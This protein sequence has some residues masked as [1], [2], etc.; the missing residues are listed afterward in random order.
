VSGGA[1]GGR[2]TVGAIV[3]RTGHVAAMA[4]VVGGSWL[5]APGAALRTWG[6][7]TALTGLALAVIEIGHGREWPWQGRG[8]ASLAHVSVLVLLAVPGAAPA[9]TMAALVLGMAGSHMP[10]AWRKWSFRLRA[11][12]DD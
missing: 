10:R 3:L 11:V 5:G 8:V 2:T 1:R 12:I 6:I 9:A 4:I 7:A